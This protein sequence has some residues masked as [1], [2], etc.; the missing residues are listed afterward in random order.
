MKFSHVF[1]IGVLMV[2][3]LATLLAT[4]KNEAAPAGFTAFTMSPAANA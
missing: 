3:T 4:S 2:T 1:V